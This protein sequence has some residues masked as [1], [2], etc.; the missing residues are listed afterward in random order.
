[1]MKCTICNETFEIDTVG[2][3]ADFQRK[4]ELC[5]TCAFWV[6]WIAR[7]TGQDADGRSVIT[8]TYEHLRIGT[9]GF[10]AERNMMLGYGGAKWWVLFSDGRAIKTNNLWYQGVVPERFRDSLQANAELVNIPYHFEVANLCPKKGFTVT[11]R[12]CA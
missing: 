2:D 8:P 10:S 6:D 11:G 12:K 4:L 5:F 7:D 1:M 9:I 3:I